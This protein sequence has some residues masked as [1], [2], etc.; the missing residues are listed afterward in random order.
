M[1]EF[2]ETEKF[3]KRCLKK[4]A[5]ITVALV[6]SFM[7]AGIPN[8]EIDARD[9]RTRSSEANTISPDKNGPNMSKS[10]NGSDVVNIV[11]PNSD[12]LSHN[13][14][15]DF[16]VG[17]GN[18]VIFNNNATSES[19]V[20]QTGGLVFKNKNLNSEAK[21][22]LTEVTGTKT[23][24]INGTI[25]VAGKKADFILANENGINVNGASFI[26]TNGV[27]LSTGKV[28]VENSKINFDVNKGN[29]SLNGV[30]TAGQYFNVIAKTIELHREVA[31][32][33]KEPKPDI[34]FVAG[35]NKVTINKNKIEKIEKNKNTNDENKYGIYASNLGAMYGNNIKLISTGSGLGVKHEGI[36]LSEKDI[37][38]NSDGDIYLTAVNSQ[39]N[40]NLKG[41]NLT[42]Q[43]KEVNVNNKNYSGTIYAQGD[44]N[45]NVDNDVNLNSALQA[46]NGDI[47]ITAKNLV[48][49]EKTSARIISN[50][51]ILLNLSEKLDVQGVMVPSVKGVSSQDLVIFTDSNGKISVKNIK[52]GQ[53]YN[54]DEVTWTA[55][56][57]IGKDIDIFSKELSNKGLISAE[58]KLKIE[59]DKILNEKN[60]VLKAADL[61]LT[62]KNSFINKG[63]IRENRKELNEVVDPNGKLNIRVTFGSLENYG[64]ISSKNIQILTQNLLN[65]LT[66]KIIATNGNI[67]ITSTAGDLLNYGEI[68]SDK[69]IF[70]I[71]SKDIINSG[72]LGGENL[73]IQAVKGNFLNAGNISSVKNLSIIVESLINAGSKEDV[74]K[75]LNDFYNYSEAELKKVDG[76]IKELNEKIAAEKDE[77]NIKTLKE[78][79]KWFTDIKDNLNNIK[80]ELSKTGNIGN[81]SGELVDIKASGDLKNEGLIDAKN[82]LNISGKN[83]E[84]KGTLQG[85]EGIFL[86]AV[87]NIING[88]RITSNKNIEIKSLSFVS[89]GNENLLNEYLELVKSYDEKDLE[90][91]VKDLESLEK[92][93]VLEKNSSKAEKIKDSI[94]SLKSKIENLREI[95]SK[96]S[97]FRD[98]GVIE[99]NNIVITTIDSLK[100]NGILI[101]NEDIT[102]KSNSDI[103]NMGTLSAGKNLKVTGSSFNSA[104]ITAG[105]NADINVKETFISKNISAGE[106]INIKGDFV[107]KGSL[108]TNKDL[109]ISGLIVTDRNTTTTVKGTAKL[110]GGADLNGDLNTGS[111]SALNQNKKFSNTGNIEVSK[112]LNISA[113]NI[114]NNNITVGGKADI[115]SDGKIVNTGNLQAKNNISLK[116]ESLNNMGNIIT[117]GKISGEFKDEFLSKDLNAKNDIYI[118]AGSVNNTNS[119]TSGKN[120]YIDAEKNISSNSIHSQEKVKLEGNSIN[121][122][123]DII[124]SGIDIKGN[125]NTEGSIQSKGDISVESSDKVTIGSKGKLVSVGDINIKTK[126]DIENS[127]MVVSNKNISADADSIKNT[128]TIWASNDVSLK[129]QDEI[130]NSSIIEAK[131]NMDLTAR[132]ITNDAGSIKAGKKLN[133]NTDSLVN[134][135]SV[136]EDI[137]IVGYK[138]LET[139][140][141]WDDTFNY[142]LDYVQI[143]IPEIVDNSYVKE[144]ASITS[145]GDLTIKG[146]EEGDKTNVLNSSGTISSS[147]NINIFGN[148]TNTSHRK[149]MPVEWFLENIKIRFYWETKLYLTNAHGSQGVSFEGTLK[150][151]FYGNHFISGRDQFYR[152]LTQNND[153]L[154]NKVLSSFLG[155]DWKVPEKP[156]PQNEWNKNA[157]FEF[158]AA[159][160]SGQ[161]LAGNNIS[162]SGGFFNNEGGQKG[163]NQKV[164]VSVG[165]EN[166]DGIISNGDVNIGDI[167]NVKEVEGVKQI[168]DVIIQ[169]GEV[170]I[171]GV[172]IKAQTGNT[173]GS[174]AVAGTISPI[175]FIEIPKGEN[176][177][178]KPAAPKPNGIQPMYETNIEFID[179]NKYFGSEYFFGQLG[180][181]KNKIGSVIGDAYYEYMLISKMIREG[182]GYTG[183]ISIDNMKS[184]LDNALKM[185]GDLGLEIGKPLTPEQI[186]KLDKDIV[187]YVE[188]EVNGQ[189]TLTPQIY[190]SNDSRVNIAAGQGNGGSA[191]VK[192]GGNIITD[193]SSFSNINGNISADGNII[194]KSEGDINNNSYG[195]V[196]GGITSNNGNI[197]LDSGKD[198]NIK[199]GTVKGDNVLVSGNN[200]NIES[201]LGTDSNGNQ[202]IS[203]KGSIQGENGIQLDANNDINIKGGSLNASG[204]E[205]KPEKKEEKN[206]NTGEEAPKKETVK[207]DVKYYE[208]LFKKDS[209][210][211]IEGDSGSINLNAKGNIN[212]EDIYATSSKVKH[213]NNS[214]GYNTDISIK[215]ESKGSELLGSNINLKSGESI[216]IKGSS[217]STNDLLEENK[218]KNLKSGSINLEAKKDVNITDSQ[219]ISYEKSSSKKMSMEKDLLTVKWADKE[220]NQ[221]LSKGSNIKTGGDL[222]ISSENDVKIQGSTTSSLGNI[223]INAKNNLEILDGRNNIKESSSE[224]RYQVLGGGVS[225]LE[226]QGS[227]SQGSSLSSGGNLNLS[228]GNNIKIVN[229]QLNSNGDTNLKAGNDISIEAGKN[230]YSEKSTSTNFGIYVEGTAGIGG[231][232]VTG[233]A[234]TSD[235]SA[236]GE[237]SSQW[238]GSEK[239]EENLDGSNEKT[240]TTSGKPH[241]DQLVNSEIGFKVEHKQNKIDETTWS[242]SSLNGNNINI[243]AGNKVDI[244]GGDYKADKNI[245]IKG[246]K[247]DSTKYEDERVEENFGFSV[248]VKQSQGVSSSI[249]DTI[250]TGLKMD[251]AIKSGNANAGVLAAQGVGAASNLLFNDMAGVFS[252]Q[253]AN[254]SIED[255]KKID[256]S[257]NI[258]SLEGENISINATE[259]DITL[260]GVEVKGKNN[261]SLDAKNNINI[262]SAKK[263]S[264]ESGFKV[265]LEAQL[266]ESAGYSALWGG[267]TDIGVGGSVNVDI[268]KNNSSTNLNSSIVSDGNINIKSGKDTNLKGA[269]IEAKK[270]AMVDVGGNL[271]I[272]SQKSI[273]DEN[274]INANAGGNVSIG[275]STNTIGKAELGFNA[276]GG[277]IWKSGETVEQSGIKS[278]GKLD[279]K[280]GGDLNLTGGVIGSETGEGNLEI[281]GNLNVKDIVTTEKQGG[282]HITVSGGFSG[283]MGVDGTIGDE[284]DK[285]ITSKATIGLKSGN[286]TVKGSTSVNGEKGSLDDINKDLSKS[287][288]VDKDIYKKGGD[289]SLS[290]STSNIK[291]AKDKVNSIKDKINS[292]KKPSS[293]SEGNT[294]ISNKN[295]NSLDQDI[296]AA[297][298]SL[299]KVIADAEKE[300]NGTN[301]STAEKNL[302]KALNNQEK[303][304][305][306]DNLSDQ[307]KYK[308][309]LLEQ[310]L[311]EQVGNIKNEIIVKNKDSLLDKIGNKEAEL[312]EKLNEL[313]GLIKQENNILNK[314]VSKNN[315]DVTISKDDKYNVLDKDN[316]FDFPKDNGERVEINDTANEKTISPEHYEGLTGEPPLYKNPP[317]HD[318]FSESLSE[319]ANNLEKQIGTLNKDIERMEKIKKITGGDFEFNSALNGL[320]K[321]VED[322]KT[323]VLNLDNKILTGLSEAEKA[324]T[325]SLS[326]KLNELLKQQETLS[327][328]GDLTETDKIYLDKLESEIKETLDSLYNRKEEAIAPN[329]VTLPSKSE[330]K[331]TVDND[332]E[333]GSNDDIWSGY[334]EEKLSSL[335]DKQKETADKAKLSDKDK[336][337]LERIEN[338]LKDLTESLNDMYT[339]ND[340]Y[341]VLDSDNAFDFPKDNGERV[342]ITDKANEEKI[343]AEHY[344]PLNALPRRKS[345]R[346]NGNN[347]SGPLPGSVVI[348]GVRQNKPKSQGTISKKGTVRN[349]AAISSPVKNQDVYKIKKSLVIGSSSDSNS[350]DGITPDSFLGN[351]D[352]KKN[353]KK[354]AEL[355]EEFYRNGVTE[356]MKLF[357]EKEDASGITSNM[358]KELLSSIL[359]TQ[360]GAEGLSKIYQANIQMKQ[361][362]ENPV[363]YEKLEE[364]LKQF[365]SAK[366]KAVTEVLLNSGLNVY[367]SITD[368]IKGK[369]GKFDLDN[370]YDAFD[371]NNP[372]F[373]S[374]KN[375]M[376][377]DVLSKHLDKENLKLTVNGQVIAIPDSLKESL[378]KQEVFAGNKEYEKETINNPS[379]KYDVLDR[380]NAF[381][382]PK[383]DGVRVDITDKANEKKIVPEHYE[384]LTGIPEKY[385]S[386]NNAKGIL[387]NGLTDKINALLDRQ[388]KIADKERLVERDKAV[389]NVIER[390]IKDLL[391]EANTKALSE[392]TAEGKNKNISFNDEVKVKFIDKNSTTLKD[393]M[394][395]DLKTNKYM[396]NSSLVNR[397]NEVTLQNQNSNTN[398]V[399]MTPH[400]KNTLDV[401]EA[402]LDNILKAQ[403][404]LINSPDKYRG[405]PEKVEKNLKKLLEDL[406]QELEE[407]AYLNPSDEYKEKLEEKLEEYKE[408][409]EKH[410]TG[411]PQKTQEL[412]S[413]LK[414]ITRSEKDIRKNIESVAKEIE[415]LPK[416]H[417]LDYLNGI[418]K[419]STFGD[420]SD[421]VTGEKDVL[422]KNPKLKNDATTEANLNTIYKELVKGEN[423]NIRKELDKELT[424]SLLND[425][426]V[427]K[428]LSE[429]KLTEENVKVLF[430]KIQGHKKKAYENVLNENFKEIPIKVL[431]PHE[432]PNIFGTNNGKEIK[433][434]LNE[435]A[436]LKTIFETLVHEM[437]HQDQ[438][439]II[440]SNN[441]ET[442]NL[443]YIYYLNSSNSGYIGEGNKHYRDQPVED[444]AFKSSEQIV[445]DV[446]ENISKNNMDSDTEDDSSDEEDFT[447]FIKASFNKKSS[448]SDNG[449]AEKYVYKEKAVPPYKNP[450]AYVESMGEI[451]KKAPVPEYKNPPT[452]GEVSESLSEKANNLEKQIGTLNRDIERMEKIKKI[453]GGDFEFNSAL[454]GLYK[455]VEDT[456]TKVLNLDNKILTG[457]SE[458]EKSKIISLS[459]KLDEL[460]KQQ[461]KLSA[462]GDLTKTDKIYLDKL[463]SEIKETLDSLY[464]RK[465]EAIA[466]NEVTLPSKSEN[467][468]AMDNDNEFGSNDDI[469]NGYVEEKLSSLLDKQKE[470]ADRVKLSDKDKKELE[471]IENELKDLLE[472]LNDTEKEETDENILF[473]KKKF[474]EKTKVK[475]TKQKLNTEEKTL[476]RGSGDIKENLKL[477]AK[478]ADKIPAEHL[479]SYLGNVLM[480]SESK[481]LVKKNKTEEGKIVVKNPTIEHDKSSAE[482]LGA[483]YKSIYD[484]EGS[485]VREEL[486]KDFMDRL[487]S[488]SEVRKLVSEN[489]PTPE[490]IKKLASLIG[491]MKKQS[492]EKILGKEYDKANLVIKGYHPT[493][494]GGLMGNTLTLYTNPN[495]TMMDYLGTITHEYTHND[496]RNIRNESS[497]EGSLLPNLYATNSSKN[498]YIDPSSSIEGYKNQPVEKEAY[499]LQKKVLKEYEVKTK[500]DVLDGENA[501]DF[502]TDNG[503]RVDI[504]DRAN[505]EKIVPEYYIPLEGNPEVLKKD[506][507]EA[508]LESLLKKQEELSK[509]ETLNETEK[510]FLNGI[511]DEIKN[512]LGTMNEKKKDELYSKESDESDYAEVVFEDFESDYADPQDVIKK[513]DEEE[514]IYAEVYGSPVYATVN[515]P[516]PKA[517]EPIYATVNKP[518]KEESIYAEIGEEGIRYKKDK[519]KTK[520]ELDPKPTKETRVVFNNG[521]KL[522]KRSE[523]DI[524]KNLKLVSE[525]SDNIPAE[526]LTEYLNNI[527]RNSEYS[528]TISGIKKSGA[529]GTGNVVLMNP[530]LNNGTP[531][532]KVLGKL[533]SDVYNKQDT[534]FREEMNNEL[535]EK[536]IS[537]PQFVEM[538]NKESEQVIYNNPKYNIL[539]NDNAFDFPKD[540]GERVE[541]KDTANEKEIT[542][543]NYIPLTGIQSKFLKFLGIT[544]LKKE[545]R[546]NVKL[547]LSD[548]HMLKEKQEELIK[549]K[550]VDGEEALELHQ[551]YNDFKEDVK[552]AIE[553]FSAKYEGASFESFK[554]SDKKLL[555]SLAEEMTNFEKNKDLFFS[556][557]QETTEIDSKGNKVIIRSEKDIRDN[558]ETIASSGKNIPNDHLNGYMNNILLNKDYKEVTSNIDNNVTLKNPELENDIKTEENILAIYDKLVRNESYTVRK[559]LNAGLSRELE[560]SR[561]INDLM[562]KKKLNKEEIIQLAEELKSL[563]KKVYKD[564]L[565]EDPLDFNIE[566]KEA[567]INSLQG[568]AGMVKG[569]L[570]LFFNP[571]NV[572]PDFVLETLV[573]EM[574]HNDQFSMANSKNTSL[575]NLKS[576][577]DL[578]TSKGGYLEKSADTYLNQPVEKEA[579]S[580]QKEILKNYKEKADKYDVL[581]KDN[582]FDFPKDNGERVEI[583]DTAN[584]EK[585]TPEH[586]E[587]LNTLPPQ[588][589]VEKKYLNSDHERYLN[590]LKDLSNYMIDTID[591]GV[592]A[593]YL[594]DLESHKESILKDIKSF[595]EQNDLE[596]IRLTPEQINILETIDR[597]LEE[598]EELLNLKYPNEFPKP[599]SQRSHIAGNNTKVITRSEQDSRDRIKAVAEHAENIPADHLAEF[600]N[601]I[602]RNKEYNDVID[603]DVDNKTV[604]INRV[605]NNDINTEKNLNKIY[606]EIEKE[607]NSK[608][609]REFLD[610]ELSKN[611]MNNKEL[612]DILKKDILNEETLIKMTEIIQKERKN[613]FEE[614]YGVEYKELPITIK[615]IREDDPHLHGEND[616]KNIIL[617]YDK[618]NDKNLYDYFTT[619]IHETAH[620]DQNN[621]ILNKEKFGLLNDLYSING[622]EG[623][624]LKKDRD[625]H[626]DQPIER[627]AYESEK[628]ASSILKKIDR[629]KDISP[630]YNKDKKILKKVNPEKGS[631]KKDENVIVRKEEDIRNNLKLVKEQVNNIPK[632]HLMEYLANVVANKEFRIIDE[633]EENK[634]KNI[635]KNP[636]L[637]N[638]RETEKDFVEIYKNI[639][640]KV[641][642]SL[643]ESLDTKF[644]GDVKK[645]EKLNSLLKKDSLTKDEVLEMAQE[646]YSIKK[647]IFEKSTG[648]EYLPVDIKIEKKKKDIEGQYNNV[649][650]T[651]Y[652][653]YNPKHDPLTNLKVISHELTHVDQHSIINSES[654]DLDSLADVYSINTL[655]NGYLQKDYTSYKEQPLETEAYG[656]EKKLDNHFPSIKRKNSFSIETL[657][658]S[659][660]R[661]KKVDKD[662]I[663]IKHFPTKG[664]G[665]IEDHSLPAYPDFSKNTLIYGASGEDHSGTPR[666]ELADIIKPS[667]EVPIIADVFLYNLSTNDTEEDNNQQVFIKE[668]EDFLEEVAKNNGEVSEEIIDKLL[669]SNNYNYWDVTSFHSDRV[670]HESE[671]KLLSQL[672]KN[673]EFVSYIKDV[674]AANLELKTVQE[675]LTNPNF[676]EYG[677]ALLRKRE[678]ILIDKIYD[679]FPKINLMKTIM[680]LDETLG[681]GGKIY[682]CLDGIATSKDSEGKLIFDEEKLN[683]ILF[684]KDSKYYDTLTSAEL[685]H[686]YNNYLSNSGLKFIIDGHVIST[687]LI[688]NLK[689]KG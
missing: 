364:G 288:T 128:G 466:P 97:S 246:K 511:E 608:A 417:V 584:E 458:A 683:D 119:I 381:D 230:E 533:Y 530:P 147:G 13:K 197:A 169:T 58:N 351:I 449:N 40:I 401:Y 253:S 365:D 131:N 17:S 443:P 658:N 392:G 625:F 654:E 257:E 342:D 376:V 615:P 114:L 69:D 319:K 103:S 406:S 394:A 178:F 204:T 488:N 203:D 348:D 156:K 52:T 562:Q 371:S 33:D 320:Y 415:N 296:K 578:N 686:L 614:K 180:Y 663:D 250:N 591:N 659:L 646:L 295:N 79:L 549:N 375:S 92:Q 239:I 3:L 421:A 587:G 637:D 192:A 445:K 164:K 48:L 434:Y 279:V 42:T 305:K 427:S 37:E 139:V 492:F 451:N 548:I 91:A 272:E 411:E 130:Y 355:S 256:K 362:P 66:G 307:D 674:Y 520:K 523:D 641:D 388:K 645:N 352:T 610:N 223:N 564:T 428:L 266:E 326:N 483:I 117:E 624:Y 531:T 2:R 418:F 110:E 377:R 138:K 183:E 453:T 529:E 482:D 43:N 347:I 338:E 303:I 125:L 289:I 12:G 391:N 72:K 568:G 213:E 166:V 612:K 506:R 412:D 465:E 196:G 181:D 552:N 193:N 448:S 298:G 244:G 532:E 269:E 267:N 369:D 81:I 504:T 108:S 423:S 556:G 152:S 27:T 432:D 627:E 63:D 222:N 660:R 260:N 189:K 187:W 121:I 638:N 422:L 259:G 99:G 263:S 127:G 220:K 98:L 115:F 251:E 143:E 201:S 599:K 254:V 237:I 150:D 644:I 68:F 429:N 380:D 581:D 314:D 70:L 318:E 420:Q 77:N 11:G 324:K 426:T 61:N 317:T 261:V 330:N 340:K 232:G 278:G 545:D 270:D 161:I 142:H 335:L 544:S 539:N 514:H 534:K 226:K 225:T 268:T 386:Q 661:K 373:N 489:N 96:I 7:I 630:L 154:L 678:D 64:N 470:I 613:I 88:G 502:P 605:L 238:G 550:N 16:S 14:F 217:L 160:A 312:S 395:E 354:L 603:T 159:N 540:D 574:T 47:K 145:G 1:R 332:N 84:N 15:I 667:R 242:E 389:L 620:Q 542:P 281:G 206:E 165:E 345:N 408:I 404:D 559:E 685:R 475:E 240:P 45:L 384:P 439:N 248:A 582:A 576:I 158:V 374:K 174:I 322:T 580:T 243:E 184:L 633:N 493:D 382:M 414:I 498:G 51:K 595:A 399:E 273:Y 316:A 585:I 292:M 57:I 228:S 93:L 87:E 515:K 287:Q 480:N 4:R 200:I 280:V 23:S 450:P 513:E 274:S 5:S 129:A 518:K 315:N 419:N 560:N 284:K 607:T 611:L 306:K 623:G 32:L 120:V 485:S 136:V 597:N 687:S 105:K 494:N 75:Y 80:T 29:V 461:E 522:I 214:E 235:M 467:K 205:V 463:E 669:N 134:K 264:S 452:Y 390:Q 668:A 28:N 444:E 252:K 162:H 653:Y 89:E 65:S 94:K 516:K 590:Y 173:A 521:D 188:V 474:K 501:F 325:I 547:A 286:I 123:K 231:V 170:T 525:Y 433:V 459:N 233:N 9:L 41:K 59:A 46:E 551:E 327:A 680:I 329:E 216:N 629:E 626:E 505:E 218:D 634:D 308:A 283:D 651:L 402:K 310:E 528:K 22:I 18:N 78:T 8:V 112:D 649:E 116:G 541:I 477:V 146:F 265:D 56:G 175:V 39:G 655:K 469:W 176:G 349:D 379:K 168:H 589:T 476:V 400:T 229:G 456:K 333:F 442:G 481:E 486:N 356:E 366:E 496:Q 275:G 328:K 571:N 36:I 682:F 508:V 622:V 358:N 361:D 491:E 577:Y 132:T 185:Q 430:D 472:S 76:I 648:E 149:E 665:N 586:Y 398:E 495:K 526:H 163:E 73:T 509:K 31:P 144:K 409:K 606:K 107:N 676:D 323:K 221:S 313:K 49:L 546:N 438:E 182:L 675:Q 487:N 95:K 616:K 208:E 677:K 536:I 282:S 573:H 454:N 579:I 565:G 650:D 688:E 83:I 241:M 86:H 155:P 104:N 300:I 262:S 558:L 457:L 285:Q 538:L 500:Y 672:L 309:S 199:G 299:D 410:F 543:E 294:T 194:I 167:N 636:K 553:G 74:E 211:I 387:K 563:K 510:S 609:M 179:P 499:E 293:S 383:D 207:K 35:N 141:R 673:E 247:V 357:F 681:N 157:T 353:N 368:V 596:K 425:K 462:K 635:I 503:E 537:N 227:F 133:I 671:K 484:R 186:N 378:K 628:I 343:V 479:N 271:N 291:D 25:E 344:E 662:K 21:T 618:N 566:F 643:R 527:T 20:S 71:S 212:I 435:G 561:V 122:K 440:N 441:P 619:A 85:K 363:I 172:T 346:N 642:L 372:E 555:E 567:P 512:I 224:G 447:S 424:N 640:E 396:F 524:R 26:N 598:Y 38:I 621:V 82:K 554:K 604:T 153:P 55:T 148:V 34:T 101:S 689:N 437:V 455:S 473:E 191:S 592:G 359:G 656:I 350:F 304:S 118:K 255:S 664:T 490:N 639:Y 62:A 602:I 652:I 593:V 50:K 297:L 106:N 684:N 341:G 370:L 339:E 30:A 557:K 195:N 570:M 321:S 360:E 10:A 657:K 416:E 497:T 202:Y 219:E 367:V 171:N 6:I 436:D 137:K 403:K 67:M 407:N 679:I 258:T 111:I 471:R 113:K 109:N 249:A 102:L 334:V 385:N 331:E 569:N 575:E 631:S 464:N 215:M 617:Y 151:A 277:N 177:I 647:D 413:D 337:E 210:D 601:N 276:G 234:S 397:D 135:S 460:L 53:V 290:G 24:N 670:N 90:K 666:D 632:E 301:I 588:K 100:N 507:K 393:G 126:G 431:P 519:S 209:A 236:Q 140:T 245:S 19:V 583:K 468:E 54:S 600:L 198:V 405:G 124:S 517:E 336:K 572:T 44:I 190:F 535:Y 302:E 311:K 60:A 594:K 446:L 478:N